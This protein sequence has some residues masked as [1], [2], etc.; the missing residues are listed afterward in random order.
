MNLFDAIIIYLACGAPFGV[1]NFVNQRNRQNR[2]F[3]KPVLISLFWFPFAIGLFQKYVTKK[4]PD[5]ILFKNEILKEQEIVETKND[6]EQIFQKNNFGVSIFE[7]KEILERYV[8]LTNALENQG[9][10]SETD[11]NF[12]EI[13]GTEN[14]YLASKCHQR[15]NRKL[16]FYHQTLAGQDFLK[17]VDRFI[18]RFPLD[19]EI[20][21]ISLK[22]V[23]LLNDEIIGKSLAIIF[24]G[25]KQSRAEINV[26]KP[27]KELWTNDLPQPQ[28]ANTLRISMNPA[29]AKINLPIKD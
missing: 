7:I 20:G 4:L 5:S 22:L 16:L 28:T 10:S 21:N 15:R 27:E 17:L 11:I 3:F 9:D 14:S 19:E 1:Y 13:A 29:T 25:R 18:S 12:Y 2:V 26:R 23:N 24:E 8:G 6:L